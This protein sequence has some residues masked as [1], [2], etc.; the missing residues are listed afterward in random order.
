MT[1]G[2]L[3][4]DYSPWI[5]RWG[6]YWRIK[7]WGSITPMAMRLA[8]TYPRTWEIRLILWRQK[9]NERENNAT[10]TTSHGLLHNPDRRNV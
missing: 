9:N 1:K 4:S 3:V 2:G 7:Q 5:G 8:E 10:S 6:V